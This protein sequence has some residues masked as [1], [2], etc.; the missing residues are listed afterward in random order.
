MKIF[1]FDWFLEKYLI[2]DFINFFFFGKNI[3]T[4]KNL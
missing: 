2:C 3:Y 4:E 1:M